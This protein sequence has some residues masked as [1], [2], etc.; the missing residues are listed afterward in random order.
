VGRRRQRGG[1]ARDVATR[2]DVGLPDFELVLFKL[3]FLQFFE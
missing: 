3:S 1:A 2:R